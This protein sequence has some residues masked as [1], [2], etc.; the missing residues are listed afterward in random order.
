MENNAQKIELLAP[1]RDAEVG[2]EA[3]NHGADAVYIGAP[4]FGARAAAGNSINDIKRLADY[5]HRFGAKVLVALNTILNDR[6]LEEAE[7][8]IHELYNAGT[9]A[10]IIQDMGILELDLPPIRLHASTQCNNRTVEQIRML[11]QIGFQRAVLAR[12][13]SITEIAA[14]RAATTIELEAFVQGALCVSY[15]GQCYLSQALCGRSANRGTC[16][17][18]CR[19]PYDLLDADGNILLKEKHLLSLKDMDRS[20]YLA[21]MIRAGITTFKIEGRLKDMQYVKNTV[22]CYRR[23]LDAVLEV[24]SGFQAASYGKT[25]FFF[26]P[27]P[28]KTFFRGA[29]DYFLHGRTADMIHPDTPKSIGEPIGRVTRI[30]KNFLETDSKKTLTNGDGLCYIQPQEQQPDKRFGGF[31]VNSVEGGRIIPAQM[32]DITIGTM[33][34]RNYDRLFDKQLQQKT[35]ERKLPLRI[36][37]SETSEGFK[38]EMTETESGH[39]AALDYPTEKQAARNTEQASQQIRTQLAKLGNT[40]YEAQSVEIRTTQT[41]FVPAA[42]LNEMRRRTVELL[43]RTKT[44]NKP[45]TNAKPLRTTGIN[46]PKQQLDYTANVYNRMA[47]QFYETNGATHIEPAYEQLPPEHTAVM[48]CKYCIKYQYGWC[49]RQH[50]AQ[51]PKEPLFLQTGKQRLQLKFD[52]KNCEMQI[53]K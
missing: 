20:D 13:L 3:I 40:C 8:L 47:R 2:I 27:D 46:L 34:Y 24:L 36:V 35:A 37:F 6:E 12:E 50:P 16:A 17:Q 9:D 21:E 14:I 52:C 49:P 43:D 32:P 26:E 33:L 10:L 11:E 19:L 39:R 23:K 7:R 38:L 44:E 18:M 45:T 22:A 42:E 15:S 30:G 1:A 51:S 28:Q 5:A 25:R 53:I 48:T 41:W 4:K 29:T 31:L